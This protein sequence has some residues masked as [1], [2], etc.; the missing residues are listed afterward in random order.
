[1][2]GRIFSLIIFLFALL[3][4]FPSSAHAVI[5]TLNS[6]TGQNQTF[7]NDTNIGIT[8]TNNI[9]SISWTGLLPIS[10]GGTGASSFTNGS[11]PFISS[12]V[13]SEDNDILYWDN[14]NKRMG[15]GTSTPQSTLHIPN[16]KLIIGGPEYTTSVPDDLGVDILGG[17]FGNF[18]IA[19][20]TG[21]GENF[22]TQV[23]IDG[24]SGGTNSSKGG[25][26]SIASGNGGLEGGNSGDIRVSSGFALNGNGGSVFI[27]AFGGNDNMGGANRNSGNIIFTVGS[28]TG[29]GSKGIFKFVPN[30][31]VN[32]N[33][34]GILNFDLIST[35]NKTFTFPNSSGTFSLLETNQTFN[36]LNKFESSSNSTIYVGSSV[37]SGCIALGDS[38]GDGVTY[39][40][41]NDG[42]LTASSTKPSICQ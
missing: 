10:R 20:R 1:M 36:G 7:S 41:A 29:S 31:T 42:I 35:S 12:G 17:S 23:S 8:S 24:G 34:G 21:D 13:F 30:S 33:L 19:G 5:R 18:S 40:T 27:D 37:K 3:I 9:H 11:I 6:Q 28:G 15:I 14:T 25:D 32:G 16:G 4:I 22:G 39:V 2:A 26:I 38:D